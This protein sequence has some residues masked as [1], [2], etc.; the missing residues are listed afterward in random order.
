MIGIVF[1]SMF[2]DVVFQGR[3]IK[4]KEI[5]MNRKLLLLS[6]PR[7]HD[8]ESTH[9]EKIYLTFDNKSLMNI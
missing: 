9:K 8:L 7:G 4:L 1:K 5:I 3:M 2:E 6:D